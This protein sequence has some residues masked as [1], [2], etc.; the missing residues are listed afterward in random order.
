MLSTTK[1]LPSLHASPRLALFSL[2]QILQIFCVHQLFAQQTGEVNAKLSFNKQVAADIF[3]TIEQQLGI[4]FNYSNEAIT[5][6]RFSFS[7]EGSTEKIVD[8][9]CSIIQR[10]CTFLESDIIAVGLEPTA[11][12]VR[13][14]SLRG[15][16]FDELNKSLPYAY[17]SIPSLGINSI[18]DING[19]F[20]IKAFVSS[21]DSLIV[22]HLGFRVKEILVSQFTRS[23]DP[24]KIV[25]APED[26]ILNEIVIVGNDQNVSSEVEV[27]TPSDDYLPSSSIDKDVFQIAQ[28]ASGV[29]LPSESISDL[30]IRGGSPDHIQ[31]KWNGI[32]VFQNSHFYGKISSINPFMVDKVKIT[33]NG[34]GSDNSG[35]ISGS[36][37]FTNEEATKKNELF[38][39]LNL[40]YANIGT[41]LSLLE[42]KLTLK[43]STRRSH[44][45]S[46]PT[47]IYSNYVDQIFQF[48]KLPDQDYYIELFEVDEFIIRNSD[49]DFDDTNITANLKVN[50][51]H[52]LSGSFV[53]INNNFDR[54]A[55]NTFTDTTE[56]DNLHQSNSGWNL[57]SKHRWNKHL[58]T[59][60]S[61]SQS[62]YTY[63]YSSFLDSRDPQSITRTQ[64][65]TLEQSQFRIDQSYIHKW[66][67]AKVGFQRDNWNVYV[68]DTDLSIADMDPYTLLRGQGSENSIY[69]NLNFTPW[70]KVKLNI[71][72]RWSY[73]DR[74]LNDRIF[75]EP[76][77]H[78][79]YIA[80]D[81]LRF[82][83]HFGKFHQQL[84][85]R[86][87]FTPLQADNGF[88]YI[89]N[90]K[91]NQDF[92]YTIE[93]AQA[94]LGTTYSVGPF[95]FGL[96]LYEKDIFNIWTSVLDFSVEENPY[97]FA[98]IEISGIELEGKYRKN[99][100]TGSIN[101]DYI[102]EQ[103]FIH[104]IDININS[105]FSQP[106]RLSVNQSLNFKKLSLSA[107]WRY[108]TGRPFSVPTSIS[109]E[110]DDEGEEFY[111]VNFPELLSDQVDDYHSL[112]LGVR[113]NMT[114]GSS[115]N[116]TLAVGLQVTNIYN[117]K[118][119]LKNQ[120]FIDYKTDPFQ[121]GLLEKSGLP[122]TYNLSVEYRM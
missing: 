69:G 58:L 80:T 103:I 106:H 20:E 33:K 116:Q 10:Q 8:K 118:N 61:F 117:R 12:T 43:L 40:L 27:L 2:F 52:Q 47:P 26:H 37:N 105:P 14:I 111:I 59:N 18:S 108:A 21:S 65:N 44:P 34:Y 50:D 115:N 84:N 113:Y 64:Q 42:D 25:L 63:N 79:S 75:K 46:W 83:A 82:H 87:F 72:M 62:E 17:L 92:I 51:Q 11:K 1:I 68:F 24:V 60:I 85:R 15:L 109:T 49:V 66:F 3:K 54:T 98:D 38:A 6:E 56:L 35:Q 73:Y 22:E 30:L 114:V 99:N 102:Q 7:A 120:Y 13:P 67:L 71:G 122:I 112:D 119:I 9:V 77:I 48:G 90:E 28:S 86:N 100:Y 74:S 36:I 91:V 57:S 101:Y 32:Q 41:N 16:I 23:E 4:T 81:K 29:Y 89:S 53:S 19:K 70:D 121:L 104:D 39:H 88:W 110:I 93:S 97:R 55:Y 76:R 95:H 94:S 31:Y 96:S 107:Q 45:D 5:Q 78:A